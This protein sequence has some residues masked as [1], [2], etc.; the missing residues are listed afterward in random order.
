MQCFFGWKGVLRPDTAQEV[1]DLTC[2]KLKDP[3]MRARKLIENS[4]V[5]LV[6]TTDDPADSLIWHEKLAADASF[7]VKVLPAWRP[8]QAMNIEK[9][10]FTD[11]IEKLSE[12]SGVVIKDFDTLLAALDRR[13]E[14][15]HAHGCRLSDHGLPYAMYAPLPR[16]QVNDTLLRRLD[17]MPLSPEEALGYKTALLLHL[18]RRYAERGWAMQLHYGCKRDNN[19]AMFG[20]LGPDTGFDAIDDHTPSAQ[21]ADFLDALACTGDL[22]RT[23]VYSLN[24]VDDDA[25]DSILGCFQKGPTVCKMQHGSAWWFNDQKQGM[26]KQLTSLANKGYLAGFVGMLTDSRSFLSY[27]RHEYF[28]RILC[29]LIGGWIEDGEYPADFGLWGKVVQDISY[30]N[31]HTYFRFPE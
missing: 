4:N 26:E 18:G 5:K 7:P 3:E 2:E 9:R 16:D 11:Y 20:R 14:F 10:S 23:L 1:W 19:S 22:P 13:M 29:N 31:A 17:G 8:D 27:P 24:P 25:I 15:F 28:R 21:L 6:C 12:A 30:N